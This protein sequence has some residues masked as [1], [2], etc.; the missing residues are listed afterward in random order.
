MMKKQ[1]VFSCAVILI[2]IAIFTA[3]LSC[4]NFGIP[5][6]VEIK[7]NAKYGLNMGFDIL[8]MNEY[9]SPK[10]M[11]ESFGNNSKL[12]VYDYNPGGTAPVKHFLIEYPAINQSI[13]ISK[14]FENLDFGTE[15]DDAMGFDESFQIEPIDIPLEVKDLSAMNT[16]FTLHDPNHPITVTIGTLGSANIT[17]AVIKTGSIT[18][19]IPKPVGWNNAVEAKVRRGTIEL[20]GGINHVYP[21]VGEIGSTD[22]NYLLYKV[23]DLTGREFTSS[24]VAL[25][26]TIELTGTQDKTFNFRLDLKVTEYESVTVDIGEVKT[27]F[28]F[29]KPLPDELKGFVKKVDCS[30]VGIGFKYKNSL[31]AASDNNVA[32]NV[33]SNFFKINSSDPKSTIQLSN[34]GQ[35][36]T[37]KILSDTKSIDLSSAGDIDINIKLTL[38]G[39]K[40]EG[41]DTLIT[42]KNISVSKTYSLALTDFQLV[43]EWTQITVDTRK[44]DRTDSTGLPIDFNNMFDSMKSG[45]SGLDDFVDA[46]E[47]ENIPAYMYMVKSSAINDI[48][49]DKSVTTFELKSK[50]DSVGNQNNLLDPNRNIYFTETMALPELNTEKTVTADFSLIPDMTRL[51]DTAFSKV[52]NER[53]TDLELDYK[54]AI[55][56]GRDFS[57]S[58]AEVDRIKASGGGLDVK[59]SIYIDIPIKLIVK[60]ETNINLMEM[61]GMGDADSDLM[62]RSEPLSADEYEKYMNAVKSIEM[63]MNMQHSVFFDAPSARINFLI[64]DKTGGGKNILGEKLYPLADLIIVLSAD[65]TKN[66][67]KSQPPYMPAIKINFPQGSGFQI[68]QSGAKFGFYGKVNVITDGSI[69]IG[70]SR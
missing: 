67:L 37:E 43:L 25:I 41:N 17:K 14:H 62:W 5:E 27:D 22:Q 68:P 36:H 26:G 19:A 15:V 7:T 53:H 4:S 32:I 60:N 66:V 42:V 48:T 45:V 29:S 13:D 56:N 35:E 11:R 30:E 20:K 70:E 40:K 61:A 6:T 44:L 34:D 18:L 54:I 51:D 52:I 55:A 12:I 3:V 28:P 69:I 57:I 10:T 50:K 63:I 49:I 8:D 21:N 33:G 58:R 38:P 23:I 39:F 1:V 47:F 59:A 65:E 46:L 64:D 16:A 31:P 24:P 2:L 9:L